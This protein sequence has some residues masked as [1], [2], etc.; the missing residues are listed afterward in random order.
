MSVVGL[1]VRASNDF[2]KVSL[3]EVIAEWLSALE[4]IETFY[5]VPQYLPVLDL[6][7]L[8]RCREIPAFIY[9][10]HSVLF[11]PYDFFRIKFTYRYSL[12]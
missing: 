2:D 6:I 1:S 11:S 9:S 7:K 10:I 3:A 12:F 4:M 8:E 5:F